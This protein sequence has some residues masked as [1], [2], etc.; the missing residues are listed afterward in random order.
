[1]SRQK[2]TMNVSANFEVKTALP[3]DARYTVPTLADLTDSKSWVS[4][5]LAFIYKGM[6]VYVISEGTLYILTADD[7]SNLSNWKA[8]TTGSIEGALIYK[9]VVAD[10]SKLPKT[11]IQE[12][13]MYY[14]TAE[15]TNYYY[16][17]LDWV[18]LGTPDRSTY[19]WKSTA[20]LN[21]SG[22]TTITISNLKR[23][24]NNAI[25]ATADDI[26]L[27]KT[28]VFDGNDKVGVITGKNGTSLTIETITTDTKSDGTY[29]TDT[30][31]STT[32]GGNT[33]I[34]GLTIA[35][36][37]LN[38]TLVYDNAGTIAVITAENNGTL[39]ATTIS[40]AGEKT[41]GTY[42]TTNTL[43]TTID[44]TTT[45]AEDEVIDLTPADI[46][47][48]ETLI[49]DAA[50]TMGVVTNHSGGNLIVTTTTIVGEKSD[51]TYITSEL[52]NTTIN[53]TTTIAIN[54]V[55]GI[56]INK[57]VLNETLIYDAEGTIGKVIAI[58]N[59]NKE[60]IVTTMT[61]AGSKDEGGELIADLKASKDVGGV[62]R[63]DIFVAG[64][65][66]ETLFR[67]ILDPVLY[68]T[69]TDPS[70]KLT[71]N[72]S[73]NIIEDGGSLSVTFT[74]AFDRGSIDPTYG[75]S[76][77]RS[78]V[79]AGYKLNSGTAQSGNSWTQTIIGS[80]PKSFT[81]TVN[82]ASGEQPKDSEGNNYDKPLAAGSVDSNTINY[83]FVNAI[84]ANTGNITTIAKLNLV[85]KTT[86]VYTFE[87]PTQTVLNPEQF[88]IPADW[89]ITSIKA[90]N[91]LSGKYEDCSN[92]FTKT[93]TTHKNA[94]NTSV[95]YN[96][97]TDNRGYSAGSRK[98][99]ITWN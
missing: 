17:N 1:M 59:S 57:I 66:F 51:G 15:Q 7:Y 13:D 87:F 92:E 22:T 23:S 68:P 26:V 50:G 61:I 11:G 84:W 31:L 95:N 4:D 34:T 27:G 89:T 91:E 43:S 98:I 94:A 3:L 6:Q 8:V 55:A 54:S 14:V 39:T 12:G 30:T 81:A 64:T 83:E 63:G 93:I 86:G 72:P 5:G 76:G 33:S 20:D 10:M 45:I 18:A 79:A 75:T 28:F 19:S 60:L 9:G 16:N 69:F 74:C 67:A 73:N 85:S 62:K 29:K 70:A 80:G 42:K 38:E 96:R 48:G 46:V 82:Y 41:D 78:G 35:N 25:S 53:E 58:N 88:D 90:Y 36:L 2:G 37:V 77:H 21:A 40:F 49:Y 47:I 56:D 52:L 24:D 32:I 97:Y 71:A 99:Q 65:S 44:G